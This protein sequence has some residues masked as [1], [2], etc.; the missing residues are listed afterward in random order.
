MQ[1]YR[2]H[3]HQ[4]TILESC[5]QI[6]I[7]PRKITDDARGRVRKGFLTERL[8]KNCIDSTAIRPITCMHASPAACQL[9]L[10]PR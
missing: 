4:R 6:D 5:S 2:F 9:S 7:N 8:C 3:V 10:Q 1:H